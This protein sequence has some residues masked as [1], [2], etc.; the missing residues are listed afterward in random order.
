MGI[1][2]E[3]KMATIVLVHG[4]WHG[5]WCWKKLLPLLR[6]QNHEIYTPTLTGLGEKSHLA[7]KNINLSTHVTDITNLLFYEDLTEIILIGHSY[8]G[9]VISGV[10][11]KVPNRIKKLVYLDACIPQNNKSIFDIIPGLENIFRK[12]TQISQGKDWIVEPFDPKNWGITKEEDLQWIKSRLS[13]MPIHTHDEPINIS[14]FERSN[15]PKTFIRCSE[16]DDTKIFAL[17]AKEG[18]NW[19]YHEIKSGHDVMV[20]YP[21]Q[22]ANVISLL[23]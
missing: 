9:A 5:G 22:L 15:M 17:V 19:D 16:F 11:E 4:S 6:E 14:N 20:L 21:E 7:T 23:V 12:R 13:P 1:V 18:K 8:G 3:D 2:K 10:A